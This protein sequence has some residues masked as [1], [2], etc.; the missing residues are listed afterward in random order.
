MISVCLLLLLVTFVDFLLAILVKLEGREDNPSHL[1]LSL[2]AKLFVQAL[3]CLVLMSDDNERLVA[4]FHHQS[5]EVLCQVN[6]VAKNKYILM[7]DKALADNC[8]VLTL[9]VDVRASFAC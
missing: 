3:R 2:K 4:A 6:A 9:F 8:S 1:E 7:N 5:G